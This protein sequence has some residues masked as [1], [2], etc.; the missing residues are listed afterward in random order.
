MEEFNCRT[1]GLP[2]DGPRKNVYKL[3]EDNVSLRTQL[4]ECGGERDIAVEEWR[5][6]KEANLDIR[7]KN[8]KL[9]QAISEAVVEIGEWI[10]KVFNEDGPDIP[11]LEE[12]ADRLSCE[13]A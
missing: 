5:I 12:I 3:I 2:L 8:L 7:A 11:E 10:S 4:A 1:C 13:G 9:K 6:L